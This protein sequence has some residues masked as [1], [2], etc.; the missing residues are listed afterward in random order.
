MDFARRN[1]RFGSSQTRRATRR[2]PRGRSPIWNGNSLCDTRT[3]RPRR[4]RARP[5]AWRAVNESGAAANE[6]PQPGR[7]TRSSRSLST[8]GPLERVNVIAL[9]ADA[10]RHCHHALPARGRRVTGE[11]RRHQV[12]ELPPIDAHVTEYHCPHVVCPSCGKTT[13]ASVPEAVAGQFGPQLTALIAYLSVG[14]RIPRRLVQSLLEDV[15]HVVDPDASSW[16][17]RGEGHHRG[18]SPSRRSSSWPRLS[19]RCESA[20]LPC[21]R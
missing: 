15:V 21:R 12:T 2:G 17:S 6:P 1:Q 5:T 8:T 16:P 14:C 10:C 7:P 4:S 13:Q 11:P 20:C 9:F 18:G 19:S 3:R